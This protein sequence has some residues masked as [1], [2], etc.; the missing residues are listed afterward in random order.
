MAFSVGTECRT[1][2]PRLHATKAI[3]L[4]AFCIFVTLS[5]SSRLYSQIA[6]S[7]TYMQ[8]SNSIKSSSTKLAL[9]AEFSMKER[10][11]KIFK[12]FQKFSSFRPLIISVYIIHVYIHVW[13]ILTLI[14]RWNFVSENNLPIESKLSTTYATDIWQL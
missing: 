1:W 8:C 12:L 4:A 9:D 3:L 10:Q 5:L 11:I 7:R 2:L 6:V 14:C 13:E